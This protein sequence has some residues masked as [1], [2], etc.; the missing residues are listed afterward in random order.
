MLRF[1]TKGSKAYVFNIKMFPSP[2]SIGIISV[3]HI[4]DVIK[5]SNIK[6]KNRIFDPYSFKNLTN[7]FVISLI[8]DYSLS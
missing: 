7:S 6:K 8:I 2:N 1:R 4:K 3:I 5:S